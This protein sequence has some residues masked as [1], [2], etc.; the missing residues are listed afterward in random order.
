MM[1]RPGQWK[2][3]PSGRLDTGGP[4]GPPLHAQPSLVRV[5]CLCVALTGA[6]VN[7]QPARLHVLDIRSA[8]DLKAFFRPDANGP[9]LVTTH[10]GGAR[11][12]FPEN[13]IETFENTLRHTWSSLEVDPRYTK[14][15]VMVLFHDPTLERTSTGTGRVID[16]TYEELQTLRLKDPAGKVTAYRIPTLDQALAWAKG[17]TVLFLDNKDVDVV[18]RA[19][20]IQKHD[21]RAWAVVMAYTFE[22]ARR[23]YD[24]DP[25]IMMQVFLPDSAAMARFETTGIPWTNVVGFVTHTE[26]K[27][28]DIFRRLAARGVMGVLGTSR[29]IDRAYRAGEI[30]RARMQ[31]RYRDAVAAGAQIVEA[32]LGVEAGEA[33]EARRA[34]APSRQRYFTI[35]DASS[36]GTVR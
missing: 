8:D 30:D 29:T 18:D 9:P 13:A 11:D 7:T 36:P 22:D 28:P 1:S 3:R 33:L 23:V 24:F 16:H 27:E 14:D 10:R 32:D 34:A 17:R 21:A 6:S 5:L 26:P 15:R 19:R 2:S 4:E 12:G 25:A 31:V 20:S 35:F